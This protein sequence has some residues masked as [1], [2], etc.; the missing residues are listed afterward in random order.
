MMY[1][2]NKHYDVYAHLGAPK[3]GEKGYKAPA[4]SYRKE[5]QGIWDQ[6]SRSLSDPEVTMAL[7]PYLEGDEDP[8]WTFEEILDVMGVPR[9]LHGKALTKADREA[10]FWFLFSLTEEADFASARRYGVEKISDRE[11]RRLKKKGLPIPQ[12]FT[13]ERAKYG[14][15]MPKWLILAMLEDVL[16][17]DHALRLVNIPLKQAIAF[18]KKH[19]SALDKVENRGVLF[20]TGIKKGD[21]LVAVA[22]AGTPSA[23]WSK[24]ASSH[25]VLELYRIASDGTVRGASSRLAGRMI[26]LL[27][28]SKRGGPDEPALFVT[29][30]LLSEAGATYR[31]LKEKGLRPT[32]ITGGLEPMGARAGSQEGLKGDFKIRWEAGEAAKEP[33][34]AILDAIGFGKGVA[35]KRKKEIR[36]R[37]KGTTY[38]ASGT[39]SA[40]E[41]RGFLQ[42]GSH[43]GTAAH[44]CKKTCLREYAK[45]AGKGNK[46]FVD[47][48]A[49]SEVAGKG[50][51]MY[52]PDG[53][54]VVVKPMS[55]KD[56]KHVFG[57]YFQL[58]E[59]LG[60][61]LYVVAPDQIG[62]QRVSFE[63][64]K[65][66]MPYLDDLT[67]LG[68][69]FIVPIQRG[70]YSM[71]EYDAALMKL[72][73]QSAYFKGRTDDL[74]RGIPMKKG[75]PSL[76]ELEAYF[77]AVKPKRV[78]LL[79]MGPNSQKWPRVKKLMEKLIP[80]AEVFM[81][82]VRIR[83]IVG[84]KKGIKPLTAAQDAAER[85][86]IAEARLRGVTEMEFFDTKTGKNLVIDEFTVLAY[87]ETWIAQSQLPRVVEWL[88]MKEKWPRP[89]SG[90]KTPSLAELKK[91]EAL[92]M[93]RRRAAGAWRRLGITHDKWCEKPKMAYL[94][95]WHESLNLRN[96]EPTPGLNTGWLSQADVKTILK[97]PDSFADWY[98]NLYVTKRKAE[99]ERMEII[100]L[101]KELWDDKVSQMAEQKVFAGEK[102]RRAVTSLSPEMLLQIP[103]FLTVRPF[104]E[105]ALPEGEKEE[106]MAIGV[107]GV[108]GAHEENLEEFAI[109]HI[110]TGRIL[111]RNLSS[112]TAAKDA[113]KDVEK[114]LGQLGAKKKLGKPFTAA[115]RAKLKKFLVRF[116][117]EA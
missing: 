79:G 67:L 95:A 36:K 75:A 58:A 9:R 32:E 18:V 8:D 46:I 38:F 44:L 61:Q 113:L 74:I 63:R 31:A 115:E 16:Q 106:V 51:P 93:E 33:N 53:P 52:D 14:H 62:N 35:Q 11:K 3:P 27:E 6:F 107:R 77:K 47:S 90:W 65:K 117:R 2:W 105:V 94:D 84:R 45:A 101:L 96:Y 89:K 66:Y 48:G 86:I 15:Q 56:W 42:A 102:K 78:H 82:S 23:R 60:S 83:A 92:C 112:R 59:A 34:W 22:L 30:S 71:A 7:H 54:P 70:Q 104:Y 1:R 25:N 28:Q 20:S 108:W 40:G 88:G 29:Y 109:A 68:V 97:S 37:R 17:P 103:E 57:I 98:R 80:H 81:D 24:Q 4:K 114:S 21:R 85:N 73:N 5:A 87:P 13:S 111:M 19:H 72:F 41:I 69:N 39:N 49:Y 110:P 43:I 116:Y 55:E 91:D 50:H 10:F 99:R 100:P 76:K 26:D 12:R 64:V